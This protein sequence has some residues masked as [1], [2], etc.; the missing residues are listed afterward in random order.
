[1]KEVEL[2]DVEATELAV[3]P[4]LPLLGPKLGKE[5]A[6]VRAALLAGDFETVEGGGFRVAGHV[7]G[8]H[9]VLVEQ[10]GREGWAVASEDGVTVALDTSLDEELEREGRALDL[11]H[12]LNT[13]RKEA[14][15]ELTDRIRVTLPAAQAEL[16]PHFDW[17]AREVL[18]VELVVDDGESE[19][20]ITRA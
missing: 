18:A 10:R 3:K 16:E 7:L 17:I 15:L 2:G 20:R 14:G 8:A 9:E 6:P 12:A 19:P 13:M 11:I 5:L 4:N 1:V